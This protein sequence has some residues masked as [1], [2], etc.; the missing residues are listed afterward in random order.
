[1]KKLFLIMLAIIVSASFAMA[2]DETDCYSWEDGGTYIS[3]YLPDDMFVANTTDQAYDGTHSLEIYEIGTTGTPQ[4]YVA[5]ITNLVEGDM[6]SASIQTL[7]LIDGNPSVRIWGHWTD[8]SDIDAY[9]GSAGGNST[10]SGGS[11]DWVELTQDWTVDAA[12]AGNGLVI[13]VRPY[14]ADPFTGSN[15]VDYLCVTH[16]AS[17]NVQFPGGSV[18]TEPT[19]W[20]TVKALYQ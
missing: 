20:S 14:N 7:D 4:A 12:H 6:V 5:W 13:E 16:P 18:A 19:S 3:S 1:M 11:T 8:P 10:Y 9:I 17:A 15:W 2:Q